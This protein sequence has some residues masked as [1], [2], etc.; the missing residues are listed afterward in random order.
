M[1]ASIYWKPVRN[2]DVLL[3]VGLRS[4]FVEAMNRAFGP[5]PWKLDGGSVQTLNGMRAVWDGQDD[6]SFETLLSA[7]ETHGTIEVWPEY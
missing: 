3:P 5:Y 1:G 4:D 6:A 7:I 2:D